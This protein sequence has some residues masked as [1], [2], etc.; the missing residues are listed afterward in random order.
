MTTR[1]NFIKGAAGVF[2]GLIAGKEVIAKVK[3]KRNPAHYQG[4][5]LKTF[6]PQHIYNELE[7]DI[8]TRCGRYPGTDRMVVN[9]GYAS[10]LRK[11]KK[12]LVEKHPLLYGNRKADG[13]I[14]FP[15]GSTLRFVN[16]YDLDDVVKVDGLEVQ[17]IDEVCAVTGSDPHPTSLEDRVMIRKILKSIVRPKYK[18]GN[19]KL[20]FKNGSVIEFESLSKGF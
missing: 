7:D 6:V 8:V 14:R 19:K 3:T 13:V 18:S 20:V 16:I 4:E 9:I 2:A 11:Y 17:E 12:R 1:R 15:N 5:P 10:H